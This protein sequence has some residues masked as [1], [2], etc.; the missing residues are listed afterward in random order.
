M[1]KKYTPVQDQH[2]KRRL[3][4]DIF[5]SDSQM[6][7]TNRINVEYAG[8]TVNEYNFQLLGRKNI[9][10]ET[11]FFFFCSLHWV[12]S[13]FPA[14]KWMEKQ[15]LHSP[16][17]IT[18]WVCFFWQKKIKLQWFKRKKILSIQFLS[19]YELGFYSC[20]Y[21]YL[22][23]NNEILWTHIS[24]LKDKFRTKQNSR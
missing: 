4:C 5:F 7:Q 12:I 24:K 15:S 21:N 1:V 8:Y 9:D 14:K 13:N 6:A 3:V 23:W 16:K 22:I 18:F 10:L 17:M 19:N 20:N 11:I 2:H